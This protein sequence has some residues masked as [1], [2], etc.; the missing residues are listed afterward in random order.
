VAKLYGCGVKAEQI[1]SKTPD[2]KRKMSSEGVPEPLK[3]VLVE[4]ERGGSLMR[5]AARAQSPEREEDQHIDPHDIGDS[6]VLVRADWAITQDPGDVRMVIELKT[7]Q[8]FGRNPRPDAQIASVH[9][10]DCQPLA[11]SLSN[12]AEKGEE[13]VGRLKDVLEQVFTQVA[14]FKAPYAVATDGI[15]F[16]FLDCGR[17]ISSHGAKND[18]PNDTKRMRVQFYVARYSDEGEDSPSVAQCLGYM[19]HQS[20]ECTPHKWITEKN[21]EDIEVAAEATEEA[22]MPS[23]EGHR[24]GHLSMMMYALSSLRAVMSRCSHEPLQS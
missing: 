1:S 24:C 13:R 8:E 10:N 16:I 6:A 23:G 19:L 7:P 21:V 18:T 22:S 14:A 20:M 4:G 2:M 3:R 11:E 17:V 5:T 15:D 12:G 9:V